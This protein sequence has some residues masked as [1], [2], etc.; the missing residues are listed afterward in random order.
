MNSTYNSELK[1]RIQFWRIKKISEIAHEQ[2]GTKLAIEIK[3]KFK[4]NLKSVYKF[5]KLNV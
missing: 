3:K 2:C 5:Y 1:L 4:S